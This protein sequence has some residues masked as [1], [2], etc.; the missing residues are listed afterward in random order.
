[1][2]TI[3]DYN[4][5]LI[6]LLHFR[7][8]NHKMRE[9]YHRNVKEFTHVKKVNVIISLWFLPNQCPI[10]VIM[11]LKKDILIYVLVY[12]GVGNIIKR[13]LA[14]LIDLIIFISLP[15]HFVNSLGFLIIPGYHISKNKSSLDIKEISDVLFAFNKLS[16]KEL[17]SFTSSHQA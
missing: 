3:E 9:I 14:S 6:L 15:Y 5:I 10:R 1:M 2:F 7:Y 12:N 17:V 11:V 13:P 16:F 8:F 4:N